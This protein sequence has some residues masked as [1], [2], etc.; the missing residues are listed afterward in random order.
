AGEKGDGRLSYRG[1]F[2]SFSAAA[3]ARSGVASGHRATVAALGY[4]LA[5]HEVHHLNLVR[6]RYLGR[7]PV[8]PP[9]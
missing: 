3:L 2:G 8:R 1:V 6:T 7:R 9:V 4:H 5:G